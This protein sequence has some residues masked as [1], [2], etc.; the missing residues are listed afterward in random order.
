ME[1]KLIPVCGWC[2]KIK[3]DGSDWTTLENYLLAHGFTDIT[4]GMCVE[5]S[6]KIFQKRLYLESYQNI[7]KIITSSLSLDEVLDLIVTN[8]VKVMNVKG[9]LLRLVNK[10]NNTLDVAAHHGLS[11]EYVNKGTVY[12][13][14]SVDDALAGKAVSVY[15]IKDN[16][17]GGRYTRAA[18]KEGI[19]SIVSIPM[20]FQDEVIGVLRM[21]TDEPRE[22]NDED[23][24]FVSAIAE[25]AALA[26]MNAKHFE[27]IVSK[28]K[29]YLRLF[30]DISS[31]ISSS[32][33][34][35]NV[36][37]MIVVKVSEAMQVKGA[38]IRLLDEKTGNFIIGGAFGVSAKYLL[39]SNSGKLEKEWLKKTPYKPVAI[40]D[41]AN[42]SWLMQKDEIIEEGVKSLLTV[43][44]ISKD[45]IIGVLKLLTGWY[46]TFTKQEI[47]FIS[48][49]SAQCAIAI[50]NAMMFEK[51]KKEASYL[52]TLKDIIKL[53]SSVPDYEQ[54]IEI[55]V[56]KLPEIM[57][58]KGVTIR[59]INKQTGKLELAAANGV[60]EKY[61]KRGSIDG[62]DSIK[63]VLTG[64]PVAIYDAATDKRIVYNEEARLEGIKSIL[65]V[66]MVFYGNIIGVLRLLTDK[67]R[68]FLDSE[69]DFAI[70]LAEEASIAI[71]NASAHKSTK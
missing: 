8:V 41:I 13:D 40:Y 20:R 65:A 69:I 36:L 67:P 7:T 37:N 30:Q 9:C 26:I 53:L 60:S 47:D 44:I 17:M 57:D 55:I 12:I 56:T 43:P 19:R 58:T 16:E 23:L 49:I 34:I 61:L 14:R 3:P 1:K 22:Y 50:E 31:A 48:A 52:K 28:E 4:H 29:E 63:M 21:Y 62:E 54:V 24:K 32:L 68:H 10:K 42:D 70:A 6:E 71:E 2:K 45:T 66:P 64:E 25:Q 15:D 51:L 39:R 46:R 38:T 11:S 59:L 5:C 35:N 18:N 27:T 33:D